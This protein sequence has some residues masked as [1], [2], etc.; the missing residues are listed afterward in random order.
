MDEAVFQKEM[1]KYKA[2]RKPDYYRV[3]MTSHKPVVKVG[4]SV[5]RKEY[6]YLF[7]LL[8]FVVGGEG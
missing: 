5:M 6:V 1:A 7:I 4:I 8:L 3:R 2:V